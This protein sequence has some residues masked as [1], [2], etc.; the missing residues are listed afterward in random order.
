TLLV[1][2]EA[3]FKTISSAINHAVRSGAKCPTEQ[4]TI[5]VAAG[6][7]KET[8]RIPPGANKITLLGAQAGVLAQE[9]FKC[10]ASGNSGEIISPKKESIIIPLGIVGFKI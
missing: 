6:V 1:S 5:R 8:P 7:Y 9:R 10:S 2:S 4:Y 3:R